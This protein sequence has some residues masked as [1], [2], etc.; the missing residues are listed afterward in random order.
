MK[1]W[2]LWIA[3]GCL[4]MLA[5]CG[6]EEEK[7]ESFATLEEVIEAHI[8]EGAEVEE[9]VQIGHTNIAAL[10]VSRNV[11]ADGY[12]KDMPKDDLTVC[13]MLL[14]ETEDG[15]VLRHATEQIKVSDFHTVSGEADWQQRENGIN[16]KFA[17]NC[18]SFGEKKPT[19]EDMTEIAG[20]GELHEREG[21]YFAF[22]LD[23]W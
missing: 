6:Q 15:F 5:G 20:Y 2:V 9:I 23:M 19:A 12:E 22:D 16:M 18:Y 21:L 10:S 13:Y 1:K 7:E 3:I 14:D 11:S 8:A 4:L 17:L